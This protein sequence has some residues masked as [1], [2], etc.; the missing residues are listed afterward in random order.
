MWYLVL[1]LYLGAHLVL[2][3]CLTKTMCDLVNVKLNEEHLRSTR[4]GANVAV[5]PKNEEETGKLS[6]PAQSWCCL[7]V[8]EMERIS[9]SAE[10]TMCLPS[11][12][13]LHVLTPWF[14][15]TTIGGKSYYHLHLREEGGWEDW[16]Q[17]HSSEPRAGLSTT[18][19]LL[20]E[21][22]FSVRF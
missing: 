1:F 19:H 16:E 18:P 11:F 6:G 2:S 3:S 17:T 14:L 20:P 10:F 22:L 8:M 4:W 5:V 9:I 21:E 13:P 12:S 7:M 15:K